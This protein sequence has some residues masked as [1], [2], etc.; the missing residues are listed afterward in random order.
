M[1]PVCRASATRLSLAVALSA[2]ITTACSPAAQSAPQ[3]I[4][5][6]NPT[7]TSAASGPSPSVAAASPTPAATPP[8]PPPLPDHVTMSLAVGNGPVDVAAGF[9]SLW[10]TDHHGASVIR[11]DPAT[12]KT[13]AL[14]NVGV[15][16]ASMTIGDGFLWEANY[17]GTISRI[18]P[19]TNTATSVGSFTHLC[20]LPTVAGGAV[21][22]YVCDVASPYVA[23]V[24][25][26]TGKTTA[27]IPAGTDQSSLL[28]ADGVLWM[29]TFPDG[30]LLRLDPLTAK[31]EQTISMS[32][33][34]WL[35]RESYGFGALWVGQF[36]DCQGT[37]TDKILKVDPHSGALE[38]SITVGRGVGVAVGN[39]AVWTYGG[40]GAIGRIDPKTLKFSP[41]TELGMTV[42]GFE[43][44]FN[45]A[46]AVSFDFARLA[47]ITTNP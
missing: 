32:G 8:G 1:R 43:I 4:A 31:V 42:S 47:Q 44:G 19:A 13:L 23:R 3:P 10:V 29:T 12:G 38:S 18:D 5:T 37:P 35:D 21:W 34:P 30:R 46:W 11:L 36:G 22:V 6:A 33:C 28:L 24:D 16:P 9:G 15:Q 14:I 41:W 7:E 17:D 27:S 25:I 45:S 20:G 26:A 40:Y 39:Q 2:V